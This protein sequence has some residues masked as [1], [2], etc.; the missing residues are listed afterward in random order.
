MYKYNV[1]YN[2]LLQNVSK[3]IWIEARA[4]SDNYNKKK[5]VLDL[6]LETCNGDKIVESRDKSY[7]LLYHIEGI[8]CG[9]V[10]PH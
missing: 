4:N 7:T 2:C 3:Y 5:I 8:R 6:E 1:F 10:K 9:R